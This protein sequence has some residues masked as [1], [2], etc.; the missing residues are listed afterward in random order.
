MYFTNTYALESRV[1]GTIIGH[2]SRRILLK[3]YI[4]FYKVGKIMMVVIQINKIFLF[5]MK[6]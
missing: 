4:V 1:T 2:L 6:Y 3:K 5:F